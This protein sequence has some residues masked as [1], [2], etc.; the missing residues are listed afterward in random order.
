V[1]TFVFYWLPVVVWMSFIFFWSARPQ[2]TT[3]TVAWQDF[4]IKK[5]AHVFEYFILGIL[6]YRSL[7]ATTNLTKKQAISAAVTWCLVYAVSDEF[8]Q[9]FTPGRTP[10]L[11]DVVIDT[12]GG[13]AGVAIS[14][15]APYN[16][17]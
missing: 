11:R 13:S 15:F 10:K 7:I 1:K 8:H 14:F 17:T 5:S 12:V 9:Y 6:V 3:S 16:K 4:T 2:I